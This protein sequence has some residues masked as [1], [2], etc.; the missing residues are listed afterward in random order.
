MQHQPTPVPLP[1]VP[2]LRIEIAIVAVVQEII[3]RL[4]DVI[5]PEMDVSAIDEALG[6]YLPAGSDYFCKWYRA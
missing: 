5:D 6:R 2:E 3:C 4:L 1:D